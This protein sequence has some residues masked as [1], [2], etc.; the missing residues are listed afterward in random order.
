ML[1]SQT[2]ADATPWNLGILGVRSHLL[3]LVGCIV[4]GSRSERVL[5]I[6][7]HSRAAVLVLAN[8]HDRL[9]KLALLDVAHARL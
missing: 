3:V 9:E 5:W 6:V 1:E 8:I 4:D 7:H 2:R